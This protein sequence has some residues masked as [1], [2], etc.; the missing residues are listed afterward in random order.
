MADE[1]KTEIAAP[2][3]PLKPLGPGDLVTLVGGWG[4][5]LQIADPKEPTGRIIDVDGAG[6]AHVTFPTIRQNVRLPLSQFKV[7][8]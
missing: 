5:H 4:S 2:P 1:E 7:K 3:A 8:L 6:I